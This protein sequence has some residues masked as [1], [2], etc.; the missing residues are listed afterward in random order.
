MGFYR[1]GTKCQ[2]L[3]PTRVRVMAIWPVIRGVGYASG[4]ASVEA[5][6][7]DSD[8]GKQGA[9][10]GTSEGNDSGSKDDASKGEGAV[11]VEPRS[12]IPQQPSS[13]ASQ[14][15]KPAGKSGP[16]GIAGRRT[17]PG[18][19]ESALA[20]KKVWP[21]EEPHLAGKTKIPLGNLQ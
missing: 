19:K 17:A 8:R 1:E 3:W 4:V 18:S 20:G 12:K 13:Q 9:V 14:A 2:Y 5:G 10:V 21:G 15:V 6:G 11:V 7:A 16:A